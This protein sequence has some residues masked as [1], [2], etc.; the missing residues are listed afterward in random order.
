M[1][2]TAC[3]LNNIMVLIA[4]CHGLNKVEFSYVYCCDYSGHLV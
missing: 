4:Q 1:A 2:I 3:Y